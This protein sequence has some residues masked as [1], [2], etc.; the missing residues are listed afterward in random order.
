MLKNPNQLGFRQEISASVK[1]YQALGGPAS[2]DGIGPETHCHTRCSGP[3]VCPHKSDNP[4]AA[5][6]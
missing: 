6:R 1:R 3:S 5:G 4:L 2:P